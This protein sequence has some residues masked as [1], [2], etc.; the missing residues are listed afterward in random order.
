MAFSSASRR[1][2]LSQ[3]KMPPQQRQRAAYLVGHGLKL[4]THGEILS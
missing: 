4:G 1:V 2:A 3:S